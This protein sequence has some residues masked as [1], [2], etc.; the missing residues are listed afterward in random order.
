VQFDIISDKFNSNCERTVYAV[1]HT[2]RVYSNDL[3]SGEV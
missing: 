2:C 3:I 1:R